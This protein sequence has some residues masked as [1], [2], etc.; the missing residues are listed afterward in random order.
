MD[1][2]GFELFRNAIFSIADEIALTVL[3]TTHSGVLK[4]KMDYSTG[5]ADAEDRR[6]GT[7]R[8]GRFAPWR[9]GAVPVRA[10]HPQRSR[11][12]RDRGTINLRIGYRLHALLS[13]AAK[14]PS[15][16]NFYSTG[17]GSSLGRD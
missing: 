1:P 5:F 7:S 4:D 9:S 3:R 14:S 6:V 16:Q 2:I 11:I 12:F 13:T 15:A 8:S 17:A 10:S